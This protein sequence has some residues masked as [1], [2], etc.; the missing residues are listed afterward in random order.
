MSQPAS[1]HTQ[2]SYAGMIGAMVVAVVVAGG[3]YLIGRPNEA[4][5]PVKTLDWTVQVKAARADQKL[6]TFA[7]TTLRDGWRARSARYFTG[8]DPHWHLGLLTDRDNYIGVDEGKDSARELVAE[9]VDKN[10][11]QGEDVRLGER[12][13]QSWTDAGGDYALT[14]TLLVDGVL[15][16][17]VIVVGTAPEDVIRTFT[18]TLEVG[19]LR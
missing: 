10:A 17:S 7:P 5:Q 1:P 14:W 16:E 2:R 13:W 11:E 4:V 15:V 6:L 8:S 3:W 9:F 12:T 18:G 19:T